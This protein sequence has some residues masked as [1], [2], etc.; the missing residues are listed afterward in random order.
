MLS[1]QSI[2]SNASNSKH[3]C[4]RVAELLKSEVGEPL[5]HK[6]GR[7]VGV[8]YAEGICIY[9]N[10]MS[11]MRLS[12]S[13]IFAEEIKEAQALMRFTNAGMS[14]TK[15]LQIFVKF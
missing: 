12:I 4:H 13:V 6:G 15:S 1:P 9:T 8:L 10:R 3:A 2:L 7:D 14:R 11:E 5:E